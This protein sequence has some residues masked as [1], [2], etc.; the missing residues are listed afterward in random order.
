MAEQGR[1]RNVVLNGRRRMRSGYKE[2]SSGF[3]GHQIVSIHRYRDISVVS[4]FSVI[5]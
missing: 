1:L 4:T 2:N 3:Q 5:F